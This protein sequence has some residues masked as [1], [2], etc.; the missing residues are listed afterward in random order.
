[1]APDIHLSGS[2]ARRARTA[3]SWRDTALS[4][5]DLPYTSLSSLTTGWP[6]ATWT[7]YVAAGFHEGAF[8]ED[9]PPTQVLMK[10]LLASHLLI[11]QPEQVTHPSPG[12]RGSGPTK[13]KVTR[14]CGSWTTNTT[15]CH[16]LQPLIPFFIRPYSSVLI[17]KSIPLE[18]ISPN[19]SFRGVLD[20]SNY[21]QRAAFWIQLHS[22]ILNSSLEV[23]KLSLSCKICLLKLL[24]WKLI[25]SLSHIF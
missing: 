16:H 6:Q 5:A 24:H 20:R 17:I 21:H 3:R 4:P 15:V 7:S 14:Q 22:N 18:I 13:S 1:M 12:A 25:N 2:P 19:S 23:Q 10:P 8:Q 11:N 9:K